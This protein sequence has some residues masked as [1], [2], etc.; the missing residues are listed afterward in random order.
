LGWDSYDQSK[1]G[2]EPQ[3]APSRILPTLPSPPSRRDPPPLAF[4]LLN[5]L[6]AW[7]LSSPTKLKGPKMPKGKKATNSPKSPRSKR[8][9]TTP[10]RQAGRA[11][12]ET[13]RPQAD[14]PIVGIGASAGGLEALD[15]FFANVP[16]D[17]RMAFVIIQHLDPTHKGVMV[18]LRDTEARLRDLLN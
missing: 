5:L 12:E 7:S 14:F 17:S 15:L 10:P 16:T 4:T 1:R 9:V 6:L 18:E 2:Q 3:V 8:A 11:A 13:V